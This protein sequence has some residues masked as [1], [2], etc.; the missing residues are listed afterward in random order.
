MRVY[1]DSSVIIAGF[2]S[3]SGGSAAL[4]KFI[5]LGIIRGITSQTVLDEILEEDKPK[6]LKRTR[7]ETE[8]FIAQCLLIIRERITEK[9]A[10]PLI[11]KHTG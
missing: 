7:E 2:L 4:F 1:F 11:G 8:Q 9:E 10:Q 6:R 5:K 3:S